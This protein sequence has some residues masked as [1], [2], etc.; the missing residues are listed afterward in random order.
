MSDRKWT[1]VGSGTFFKWD[2]PGQEIVGYWRGQKDGK[3]GPVGT[4]DQGPKGRVTFALHT[5]LLSKMEEIA[6]G[7]M[8]KIVYTGKQTAKGS[9]NEFKA[10]DV[11][12]AEG[13]KPAEEEIP[14]ATGLKAVGGG[15]PFEDPITGE[16]RF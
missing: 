16:T 11:F 10:F 14:P 6:E 7:M 9:G 4:V 8:V 13:D 2:T 15:I 1:Q 12:T 3:F 5:A